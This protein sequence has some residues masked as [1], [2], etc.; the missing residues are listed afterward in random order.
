MDRKK[1]IEND[2]WLASQLQTIRD[3]K[4]PQKV[5]VCQSVMQRIAD[6]PI[7]KAVTVSKRHYGRIATIAAAACFAI[8]VGVTAFLTRNQLQAATAAQ[9]DLTNRFF[10][11]YDYCHD[12]ANDET[13]EDA[14]Y[15]DNPITQF[16]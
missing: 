14:A 15:Y 11:V 5:D 3:M 4:C 10:E 2:L 13:I 16:I 8:A 6:C 1:E 9:Q 7:L 12:Y